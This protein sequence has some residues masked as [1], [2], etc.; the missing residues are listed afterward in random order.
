MANNSPIF[1][2]LGDI[3]GGDVMNTSGSITTSDYSGQ[4]IYNVVV[5]TAD[6]TNGGYVQRLRF[7]ASGTNAATAARIYLNNG[8]S[9]LPAAISAVAGTPTGTPS[10]SGGTL[11]TGS[12]YAKI[13]A[14]DQYGSRTSASAETAAVSVTGPT[15]SISWNWTAVTGAASY[16]IYVGPVTQGQLSYFTSTTNSYTQTTAIGTRD[17]LSVSINNNNIFYG[18]ISLPAITAS[19]TA[20][21]VDI[22]YPINMALP[23][24]YRVLVGLTSNVVGGWT[25]VAIGGSY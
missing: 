6:A 18:E 20:A 7:K 17:N 12:Y 23:P 24:G 25:T 11:A 9:R 15:G 4:G 19:N 14:V 3:Q 21:T 22:D 16:R 2:K 1:S 10:A 13:I 8:Q 5:F